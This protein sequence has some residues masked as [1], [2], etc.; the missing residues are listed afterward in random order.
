M[1]FL[2]KLLVAA[3]S[4]FIREMALFLK[5]LHESRI[6]CREEMKVYYVAHFNTTDMIAQIRITFRPSFG[7]LELGG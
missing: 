5:L 4:K 3:D 6:D 7:A 1:H 2:L